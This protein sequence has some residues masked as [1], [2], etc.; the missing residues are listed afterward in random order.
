MADGGQVEG[1]RIA[2]ASSKRNVESRAARFLDKPD[3][4][5]NA[6]L[7]TGKRLVVTKH[8]YPALSETARTGDEDTILVFEE[9]T[10]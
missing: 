5:T 8:A 3:S 10:C 7:P 6:A 4:H 9:K 1:N 2:R